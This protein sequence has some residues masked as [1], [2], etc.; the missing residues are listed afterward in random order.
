MADQR[1]AQRMPQR[2]PPRVVVTSLNEFDYDESKRP[3]DMTYK[4]VR[5]TLGGQEDPRNQILHDMNGWTPV[6]AD[7]HPELAGRTPKPGQAII[8]GGQMLMQLPKQYAEESDEVEK[9]AARNQ[10]ETQIVRLGQ[11]ARQQGAKGIHRNKGLV[12]DSEPEFVA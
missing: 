9:F 11:Q 8:R 7:R 5:V 1:P 12:T 2:L 6:P 4:W 10:L 3:H